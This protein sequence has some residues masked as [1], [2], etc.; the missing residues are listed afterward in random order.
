MVALN[1]TAVKSSFGSKIRADLYIFCLFYYILGRKI[2]PSSSRSKIF[3][4]FCNPSRVCVGLLRS[5]F[6]LVSQSSI[7][8]LRWRYIWLCLSTCLLL[9]SFILASCSSG[10]VEG[11]TVVPTPKPTIQQVAL[12]KL[13]W[14]N[15][16]FIVFRDEHAPVTLTPGG[17]STVTTTATAGAT[18]TATA[19]ST[20]T[21]VSSPTTLT[22]WSQIK[23]NLGFT[24]FLPA[25]LPSQTC[26][27]SASGTLN[28][29]IFG[30]NFIIGY[31]LADNSPLSLSEA[32]VRTNSRA[33]QCTSSKGGASQTAQTP[34]T[35]SSPT[36]GPTQAPVLLCTGVK[37]NTS[38]VFSRSGSEQSLRQFFDALQPDVAWVPG[39]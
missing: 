19:G 35:T 10:N 38:I 29:P 11:G 17:T 36:A 25:V 22:E 33:F 7:L 24:V 14:C 34:R 4:R 15:K 16:P 2:F 21:A 13:H 27:V 18:A 23:P 31:L 28:D 8:V 37:D 6:M 12:S 32:P 30:G 3:W 5:F 39:S 20:P 1:Q 26:L 9:S